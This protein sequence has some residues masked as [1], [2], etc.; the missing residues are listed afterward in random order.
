DL[1]VVRL[2]SP[3]A[4]DVDVATPG[5]E[6]R[7][8]RDEVLHPHGRG[9][10]AVLHGTDPGLAQVVP[11]RPGEVTDDVGVVDHAGPAHVDD[12]R[13]RLGGDDY[14]VRVELAV[15][16]EPGIYVV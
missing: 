12:R 9:L 8:G 13:V 16:L 15:H 14:A 7:V 2:R 5:R 1:A 4:G 6:P 11:A 10:L 3:V